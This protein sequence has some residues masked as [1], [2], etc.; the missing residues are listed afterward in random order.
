[1]QKGQI[2]IVKRL[3]LRRFLNKNMIGMNYVNRQDIQ[4]KKIGG[5]IVQKAIDNRIKDSFLETHHKDCISINPR[6]LKSIGEY[7]EKS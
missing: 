2:D 7:L 3:I 4:V 1:M 6:M 5:N